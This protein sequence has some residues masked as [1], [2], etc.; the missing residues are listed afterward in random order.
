MLLIHRPTR[1]LGAQL[2]KGGHRGPYSMRSLLKI[3]KPL[4]PTPHW[5]PPVSGPLG[6]GARQ[7]AKGR[8]SASKPS[9]PDRFYLKGR[10][11]KI[12]QRVWERL[13]TLRT[14]IVF[15]RI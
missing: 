4:R 7:A 10:N 5:V 12:T 8:L 15:E 1:Q 9:S 3:D 11:E 14:L 2:D 6:P 13:A